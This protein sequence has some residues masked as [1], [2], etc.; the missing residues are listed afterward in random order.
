MRDN[1]LMDKFWTDNSTVNMMVRHAK[2]VKARRL[3][4]PTVNTKN[5]I[6]NDRYIL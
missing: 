4:Y 1:D 6:D 2:H 5:N 3:L